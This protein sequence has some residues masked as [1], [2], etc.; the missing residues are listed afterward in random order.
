M[1]II[2]LNADLGEGVGGDPAQLDAALLRLVTSASI[3]CGGHAGSPDSM[4]R[5]CEQAAEYGVAIGAQISYVDVENFGRRKL[6]VPPM[7]LVQQ[8]EEQIEL[9]DEIA[10]TCGT[11]VTYVKPHGALYNA[12]ADDAAIVHAIID[13]IETVAQS[14]TQALTQ[15]PAEFPRVR[16]PRSLVLLGL[17]GSSFERVAR[18]RDQD[19]IPEAFADR[20]Y[21]AT[22]RLVPRHVDGAVL[23]DPNLVTSQALHLAVQ[24]QVT[25]N[26]GST[27]AV[28]ARSLCVHGDTP[29]AVKLLTHV[30]DALWMQGLTLT[31]FAPPPIRLLS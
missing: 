23:H 20:A 10:R 14:P 11:Q 15:P 24:H 16:E 19:F 28:Q 17:A 8:L 21:T 7:V 6:D 31:A 5:V 12:A 22:G 26:D 1:S 18:E 2:D 3:A 30:R 29:D 25:S 9:L 13:A 27:I 4:A